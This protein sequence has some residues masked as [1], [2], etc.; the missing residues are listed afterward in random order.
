MLMRPS[1]PVLL[2]TAAAIMC[3]IAT[4]LGGTLPREQCTIMK[5][6]LGIPPLGIVSANP[7]RVAVVAQ[8]WFDWYH[9]HTDFRG[10]K[11]FV[12]EYK[13]VPLFAAYIGLG[14]ASAA[15]LTE[16]LIAYGAKS[17]IR[18]GTNDYNVTASSEHEVNVVQR[19]HGLVGLMQDYGIDREQWGMGID[20]NKELVAALL[21]TARTQFPQ[22]NTKLAVGYNIDAFYSFFNPN[23]VAANAATVRQLQKKYETVDGATVRDMETCAVL[24]MGKLRGIQAASVLQ[25]VIKH[26]DKHEDTG[27]VGIPIVLET[28]RSLHL[29]KN[30]T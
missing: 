6:P 4:V 28:L 22:I 20:S 24:M 11:V 19:C 3:L 8:K 29:K 26:G 9:V 30:A 5:S 17:I 10:Y 15:F 27:T 1:T 18:L 14:S 7:D 23:A 12:G 16:E 13:R 25:S 21:D 2:F